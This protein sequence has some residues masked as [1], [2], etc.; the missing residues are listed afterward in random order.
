MVKYLKTAAYHTSFIYMLGEQFY[1]NKG[2]IT[3]HEVLEVV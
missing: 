3:N 2:R 1:A